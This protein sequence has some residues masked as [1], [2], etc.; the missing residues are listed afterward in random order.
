MT[1]P[2]SDDEMRALCE[3]I[4]RGPWIERCGDIGGGVIL[5][6]GKKVDDEMFN[7]AARSWIPGAL[8][9]LDMLRRAMETRRT[10]DATTIQFFRAPEAIEHFGLGQSTVYSCTPPPPSSGA[11]P[12]V[13][14]VE[15]G[16]GGL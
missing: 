7:E 11:L 3:R 2:I 9:R 14:D 12:E 6:E 1:T 15:T 16:G 5:R 4:T 13:G 10:I 8:E